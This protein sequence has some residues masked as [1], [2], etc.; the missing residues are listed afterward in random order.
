MVGLFCFLSYRPSQSVY[1][2]HDVFVLPI[3]SRYFTRSQPSSI[4]L[5]CNVVVTAKST[6]DGQK[7]VYFFS[8]VEIFLPPAKQESHDPPQRDPTPLTFENDD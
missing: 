8:S 7:S 6:D 5:P 2:K 3:F 4:F 1:T